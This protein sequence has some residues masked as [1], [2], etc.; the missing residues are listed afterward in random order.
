M[1]IAR[2]CLQNISIEYGGKRNLKNNN[3]ATKLWK[4]KT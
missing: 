4:I 3:N 2:L 1:W